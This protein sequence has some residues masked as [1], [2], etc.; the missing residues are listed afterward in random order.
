MY[1]TFPSKDPVA[2]LLKHTIHNVQKNRFTKSSGYVK[3]RPS[4]SIAIP[5]RDC[6]C[7]YLIIFPGTPYCT[8]EVI[9]RGPCWSDC[10]CWTHWAAKNSTGLKNP[11]KKRNDRIAKALHI[12]V[13]CLSPQLEPCSRPPLSPPKITRTK[14]NE[15][16]FRCRQTSL[17]RLAIGWLPFKSFRNPACKTAV[18]NADHRVIMKKKKRKRINTKLNGKHRPINSETRRR[19]RATIKFICEKD[20]S[21]IVFFSFSLVSPMPWYPRCCLFSVL[22]ENVVYLYIS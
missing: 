22:R 2:C 6:I 1:L 11:K 5:K 19:G 13:W 3:P 4:N 7:L 16:Y 15:T 10:I 9:S 8:A 21:C 20:V 14:K 12:F 17:F 18:H